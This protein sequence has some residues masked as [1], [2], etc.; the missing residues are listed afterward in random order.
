MS[1]EK[2]ETVAPPGQYR[3]CEWDTFDRKYIDSTDWT[4]LKFAV[5]CAG[6]LAEEDAKL[7]GSDNALRAE[8]HI[9]DEMGTI[10]YKAMPR[11][12]GFVDPDGKFLAQC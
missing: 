12:R 6:R 8:F 7:F 2:I 5:E 4:R 1:D 11:F 9:Y 10:I 3:V